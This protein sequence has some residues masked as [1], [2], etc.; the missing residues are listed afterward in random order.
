MTEEEKM[1]FWGDLVEPM[2]AL[3]GGLLVRG[4]YKLADVVKAI[5]DKAENAAL[6]EREAC[7]R[8]CIEMA[9]W[10]GDLVTAAYD[11]A[12]DAI[13]KRGQG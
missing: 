9:S 7:A 1:V 5:V 12:A 6:E 10:H 2:T 11:S 13:R 4:E 8:L 3:L